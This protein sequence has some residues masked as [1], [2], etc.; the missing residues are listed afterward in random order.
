MSAEPPGGAPLA[1]EAVSSVAPVSNLDTRAPCVRASERTSRP[2][3][4]RRSAK[5]SYERHLIVQPTA[6]TSAGSISPPSTT[7][8][9]ARRR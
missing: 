4:E 2:G 3:D 5:P 9:S 1:P 7:A 8:S 6:G